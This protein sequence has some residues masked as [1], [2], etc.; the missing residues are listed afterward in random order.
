MTG[1]CRPG[2]QENEMPDNKGGDAVAPATAHAQQAVSLFMGLQWVHA[3]ALHI[4]HPGLQKHG[5]S[6]AEFDVLATLCNHGDRHEMT[7]SQIQAQMVITS[8]GL[9]KVMR[10]L[11]QRRLVERRQDD[12]DLRIKPVRLTASGL[13]L[14]EQAMADAVAATGDWL[15]NRLTPE[16]LDT[17]ATL[18]ARLD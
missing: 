6:C 1:P 11:Q 14:I 10:Q 16:Q 4:M 7:P 2:E 12:T 9:T 18:L 3:R 13:R 17:L 5:L 15:R 8:G